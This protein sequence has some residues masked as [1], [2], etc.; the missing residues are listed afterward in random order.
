MKSYNKMIGDRML[1]VSYD[2]LVKN[3]NDESQRIFDYIGLEGYHF[4]E[5]KRG[6]NYFS[7]TASSAQVQQPISTQS[8]GGWRRHEAFLEPVLIALQKQQQRLGLRVYEP[9]T[10]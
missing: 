8:L 10:D 9:K 4:D 2:E 7:R 3:P 1:S 6:Q 5:A